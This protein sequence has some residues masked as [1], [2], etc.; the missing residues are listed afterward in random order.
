MT[1][2]INIEEFELDLD[3]LHRRAVDLT[4]ELGNV[5]YALRE[6]RRKLEML[7]A[8]LDAQMYEQT[9]ELKEANARLRESQRLQSIFWPID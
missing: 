7:A 5:N 3:Q 6:T 2:Q 1:T 8:T 9:R 4:R